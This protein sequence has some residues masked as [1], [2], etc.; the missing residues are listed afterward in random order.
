MSTISQFEKQTLMLKEE[1]KA[2]K[3]REHNLREVIA[4]FT[5]SSKLMDRMVGEQIPTENK[6]GL[7][8]NPSY[9][10]HIFLTK[11]TDPSTSGGLKSVFV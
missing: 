7:G 3:V 4:T 6:A 9:P 8:Y 1:C 2:R 11:P 10:S 5:N